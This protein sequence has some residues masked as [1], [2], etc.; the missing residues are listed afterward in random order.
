MQIFEQGVLLR[1]CLQ[2]TLFVWGTLAVLSTALAQ[3]QTHASELDTLAAAREIWLKG[4]PAQALEML[5]E[6]MKTFPDFTPFEKLRG[7]IFSTIRQREE[8]LEAYEH[9][10][11]RA[12]R[13]L[14]VRWAKWSVLARSG[15]ADLAIEEFQRIAKE[16]A[17]NPLVHLRLAQ[18]LRTLDRLEEAVGEYRLAA[19][20]VPELPGWRLSLAR[21]LFDVLQYDEARKEVEA[22]LRVVPKRSPIETAARNLLMV[23]YGVTKERGRRFQPIFSPDGSA[24]DRKAWALIRHDAWKLYASGRFQEAEPLL[25]QVLEL[26]PSDHRATYELGVTLMELGQ[27]EES[28]Q[29]LQKGIDLGPTS[30]TFS[31]MFLDSIFRIGQALAHMEKWE[32]ALLHFEILQELSAG[33]ASTT[34]E[35]PAP[36]EGEQENPDDPPVLP[37][38]PVLDPEKV[39]MWIEKVRPH[40][41]RT[42]SAVSPSQAVPPSSVDPSSTGETEPEF[43]VAPPKNFEPMYRRVGLMGRD[44]DFSWFRYV[45]PSKMIMRDDMRMGAHEFIPLDPG[46]TFLPDQEDLYLVFALA[47]PSYDEVVLTAECFQE[48]T[49]ISSQQAGVVQDQVVMSM[50]EQSGY[51]RL[52][53]P[54]EGWPIGLYRCGLFVGE[55]ISAYNQADEVRFRILTPSGS[56]LSSS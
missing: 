25:R 51:F 5:N 23:V 19:D 30:G 55:E 13:A 12:P 6:G 3:P 26:R 16:D 11:E 40:V 38:V 9:V 15:Q 7:D 53:R 47:T 14:D 37:G 41:A 28:I 29:W 2:V 4:L 44:A 8:A 27:Y 48:T 52:Q 31:E 18:E 49:K 43:D 45:I 24:A 10:L 50:N 36:L 21:A 1:R 39:A 22:V 35:T 32:E 17:G 33:P 20:L 42:E 34:E 46:D 56:H 54:R